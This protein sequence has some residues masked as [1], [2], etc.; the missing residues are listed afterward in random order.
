[1]VLGFLFYVEFVLLCFENVGLV[2]GRIC[3]YKVNN[4]DHE[5]QCANQCF[6]LLLADCEERNHAQLIK[7]DEDKG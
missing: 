7:H 3:S 2:H 1:M 6:Q 5:D 4:G